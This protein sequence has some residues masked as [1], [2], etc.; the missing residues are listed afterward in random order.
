MLDQLRA[1]DRSGLVVIAT[2]DRVRHLAE[3]ERGLD[4]PS[5]P[6]LRLDLRYLGDI[7]GAACSIG[8]AAAIQ[9]SFLTR[10]AFQGGR[11]FRVIAA[12][13]TWLAGAGELG[14]RCA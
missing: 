1:E 9:S 11:P 6:V 2:R 3:Y 4:H 8:S 10:T 12:H 7:D 13:E 14:R 5:D